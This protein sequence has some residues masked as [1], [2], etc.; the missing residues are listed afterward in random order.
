[1][2]GMKTPRGEAAGG[3]E[4]GRGEAVV[5]VEAETRETGLPLGG[6]WYDIE[7][8]MK[9]LSIVAVDLFLAKI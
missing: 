8:P 1:M 6:G 4:T 2:R 5:I 9:G 3:T 7:R